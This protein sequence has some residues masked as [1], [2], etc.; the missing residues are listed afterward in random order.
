MKIMILLGSTI[1]SSIGWWIGS[2]DGTM[3]AFFV[4]TIGTG[5]GIWA[6]R[7]LAIHFGM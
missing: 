3:M 6:G 2:F 7:R 4:S 5:F 1:G